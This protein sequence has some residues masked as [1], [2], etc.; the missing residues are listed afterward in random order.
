MAYCLR[1]FQRRRRWLILFFCTLFICLC[2]PSLSFTASTSVQVQ[3][4]SR[5]LQQVA[6][7]GVARY[8]MDDFAGAI[9]LWETA[10]EQAQTNPPTADQATLLEYLAR[11]HR[12][13]G[14]TST[15]LTYWESAVEATE[16]LGDSQQ[17]G[18]LLS[19]QAQTYSQLG[20]Y[21]KAI[22]L[23][24]GSHNPNACLD[25]SALSLAQ[26][27]QD[28]LAEAS[29]LGSLGEA[30]RLQRDYD[31]AIAAL[32]QSIAIA[33]SINQTTYQTSNLYSLGTVYTRKAQAQYRRAAFAQTAEDE[34]NATQLEAK[35][36]GF[37]Q[38]AQQYFEESLAMAQQQQ[39]VDSE[40]RSQLS[41][42][43]L[44]R[45][46]GAANLATV[47][48]SAAQSVLPQ[49]SNSH[50][51][52]NDTITLANLIQFS[53]Q[54]DTYT[55]FS[56]CFS[57]S[58]NPEAQR[59]LTEAIQ[60]AQALKDSRGESFALGTLGH[61]YEC[62]GDFATASELTQQ[63]EL[64]ADQQLQGRDSLY[65][66]QW[67]TGR[68]LR[69][70][71]QREGAIAA[72]QQ[73]VN[74]L[75]LIR[76]DLLVSDRELQFDFRDTVEPVYR[77]LMALQLA[78]SETNANGKQST[79]PLPAVSLG[80]AT[81]TLESL[82]LAELQDYFGSD[83]EIVPFTETQ[84]GLV[85]AGSHTAVITSITFDERTAVIASFPSGDRQIAWI[86][87]AATT[88]RRDINTFRRQLENYYDPTPFDTGLAEQLY[89]LLIQ[90][91]DAPLAAE[92]IDTLVFVNDGILRSIPMGALYDGER[93]LVETYA[94]ATVPTLSLTTRSD[95]D[96]SRINML[97]LGMTE[98]AT[99]EDT[100]Y[101]AL[102]YV[103]QEISA[104]QTV[105]PN[106]KVLRNQSFTEQQL[107][108]ELEDSAY[109]VLHLSTHAQ[110]GVEP[111][112]TFL[113]TGQSEK[114]TFGEIDRL[115][116]SVSSRDEPIELLALTACET[117]VGD[118]RAALGIGGVVIRAGAKSAIASL[119]SIN[120]AITADITGQ[121][122]ENLVDRNMG[123]A[124]AL[125]AA[126][127]NMIEAGIRPSGWSPLIVVGNWQ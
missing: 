72:Y 61:W 55:L 14:Q 111:E 113:V 95:L 6:N 64:A 65:L 58:G 123:K 56:Q 40:W 74:T 126:Q 76:N 98:T 108:Q 52:I 16:K 41:L 42:I 86:P 104:I 115:I 85:G 70:Q 27:T 2:G 48:Q 8:E 68:I 81:S 47:A 22:A 34:R 99:V 78:A 38:T 110:F 15:S 80:A 50:Q 101:D 32:G 46:L 28:T 17:L 124:K 35:A 24:C 88:I 4:Q 109:S 53:D 87:Q 63:A 122:Y 94:T 45:R 79:A 1:F 31:G 75:E 103:D 36:T 21:R 10:L 112:D 44:Y 5:S 127:I 66:W 7:E 29:A 90:P 92:Q 114:L 33:K 37:D 51:K 82:K 3:A 118:D 23:L 93:F 71:G 91:F 105:V 49:V 97:I 59:L 26:T 119:W 89:S 9:A 60:Q 69:R 30:L 18:R 62:Q 57:N 67:Q 100:F 12:R 11:V 54:T 77:E 116:R 25:R 125:Q 84:R 96:P 120:D 102:Q 20:Q 83:C 43:P 121:F 73:A 107:S 13:I 39:D 19:E 117:A 106:T